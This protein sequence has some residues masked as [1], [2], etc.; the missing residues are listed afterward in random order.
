MRAPKNKYAKSVGQTIWNATVDLKL[1]HCSSYRQSG[2]ESEEGERT[3]D[4][5]AF[6][7]LQTRG[8]ELW[9]GVSMWIQDDGPR[10]GASRGH[11]AST[12]I[13]LGIV[14]RTPLGFFFT[15]LRG[16]SLSESGEKRGYCSQ[17]TK[18]QSSP[19]R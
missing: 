18:F 3:L 15:V 5:V 10:V 14:D 6:Y 4:L 7:M 17:R 9:L 13:E 16:R 19:I 8:S 11:D 2:I 1:G 12:C